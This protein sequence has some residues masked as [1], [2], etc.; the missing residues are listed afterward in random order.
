MIGGGIDSHGN[1]GYL[2]DANNSYIYLLMLRP[3]E[4]HETLYKEQMQTG[5]VNEYNDLPAMVVIRS[6]WPN[7]YQCTF[8]PQF[9]TSIKNTFAS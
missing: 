8:L 5:V 7:T 3:T 4:E 2:I 1:H 6:S 9:D